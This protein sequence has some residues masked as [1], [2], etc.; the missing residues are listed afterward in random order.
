MKFALFVDGMGSVSL[1]LSQSEI[2]S[3]VEAMVAW[4]EAVEGVVENPDEFVDKLMNSVTKWSQKNPDKAMVLLAL[5]QMGQ[6]Q[7]AGFNTAAEES[8]G[9]TDAFF[10]A[11]GDPFDEIFGSFNLK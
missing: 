7:T 10:R 9:G 6:T 4:A 3:L 11:Q 2:D 1:E 8:M 5:A